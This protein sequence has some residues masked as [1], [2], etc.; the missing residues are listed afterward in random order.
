MSKNKIIYTHANTNTDIEIIVPDEAPT[1]TSHLSTR[2]KRGFLE[3]SKRSY[4]NVLKEFENGLSVI[5]Q[6]DKNDRSV[7]FEKWHGCKLESIYFREHDI[8]KVFFNFE[9]YEITYRNKETKTYE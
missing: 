7:L 6:E 8:V 3:I 4:L 1:P 9:K 2:D 5:T